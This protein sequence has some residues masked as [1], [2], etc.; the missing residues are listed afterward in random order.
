ML[1]PQAIENR[2]FVVDG[3]L[4][5]SAGM[6]AGIDIALRLIADECGAALAASIDMPEFDWNMAT[7]AAV[8]N[9]TECH[10]LRLFIEHAQVS[11][12]DYLRS[13]RLEGAR[14]S[15]MAQA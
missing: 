2:V 4:A 11:P 3:P 8:G 13:I 15:S 14:R 6:T 7:L 9:S 12:L 5:S 1:A 10:L